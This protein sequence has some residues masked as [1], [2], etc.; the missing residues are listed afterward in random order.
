MNRKKIIALIVVIAIFIIGLFIFAY[1][2]SFHK[3]TFSVEKSLTAVVYKSDDSKKVTILTIGSS[4]SSSSQSSSFQK[5]VYC[6]VAQ[7]SQFDTTPTCFT[8]SNK[9]V[10]VTVNPDYSSTYLQSLLTSEQD[11]INSIITTK[12]APLMGQYTLNNGQLYE[13]GQWYGTTLTQNVDPSDVGDTYRVILEQV[14]GT[15]TIIAYP[16][17]VL[18]KYTYPQVPFSILDSVNQILGTS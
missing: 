7:G 18:S 12:Y 17:I 5:G 2:H 15:W 4:G 14:G 6:A 3:V 10:T 16:Q 1:I 9:D 13:K 8:V 11:T